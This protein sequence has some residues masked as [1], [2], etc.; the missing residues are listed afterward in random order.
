MSKKKTP[1]PQPSPNR[2]PPKRPEPPKIIPL[3]RDNPDKEEKSWTIRP[4]KS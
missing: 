4:P 2:N 3:R 1:K